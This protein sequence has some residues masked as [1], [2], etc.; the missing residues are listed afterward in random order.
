MG[1]LS[2]NAILAKARSM[3][4]KKL[5]END[6]SE[7]LKRRSVNEIVAYL[8]N[9]TEYANVLADIKENTVHRGQLEALLS[10]EY[11]ARSSRLMRYASK[12]ESEFYNLGIISGEIELLL[13]KIR[14]LNSEIYTGY[15]LNIPEYL[16]KKASFDMYGLINANKYDDVLELV[17]KTRYYKLL[18]ELKP[19]PNQTMDYNVLEIQLKRLYYD[20]FVRVVKKLYKG[21][22]QKD[23]LTVLYTLIELQ[24]IT[25]IY[26]L[27]KFF[28]ASPEHI[29]ETVYLEY[30]RMP[31]SVM[32]DLIASPDAET[33]LKKLSESRYKFYIDDKEYVFIE[34]YAE[35][36]KYNLAKRY[37][38][39]ST[40][41][42]LVFLTYQIV[43]NIE[44]DNLKHIIEG[45]R[46]GEPASNI[47]K[48]LIY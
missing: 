42:A 12:S 21:K 44:I 48:M 37:M 16:A 46:Y 20:E 5:T 47:E 14:I 17:K 1:S 2:S 19:E 43:F 33:L 29:R 35:K 38:R 32:E 18:S 4:A 8:K 31:K 25:K 22:K 40:D 28:N 3:Y 23:I 9:D 34:Y 10:K 7:L 45:I 6:Y 13:S 41:A 27:K 30:S 39:F 15:D 36:I 24:N 26:R 11:Y